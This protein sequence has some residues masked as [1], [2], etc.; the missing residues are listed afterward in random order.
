MAGKPSMSA[1]IGFR[2][3]RIATVAAILPSLLMVLIAPAAVT[4]SVKRI[5]TAATRNDETQATEDHD[6]DNFLKYAHF[7]LL[8]GKCPANVLNARSSRAL[9]GLGLNTVKLK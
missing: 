7:A 2:P 6:A 5:K 8:G 4:A 9:T 1:S 3:R